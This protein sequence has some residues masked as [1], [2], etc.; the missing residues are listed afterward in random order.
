MFAAITKIQSKH[1][2]KITRYLSRFV[3]LRIKVKIFML[4]PNNIV[5]IVFCIIYK[6]CTSNKFNVFESSRHRF[7]T[8]VSVSPFFRFRDL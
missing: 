4:Q 8:T 1:S 5:I 6:Y 7:R 2:E 3:R